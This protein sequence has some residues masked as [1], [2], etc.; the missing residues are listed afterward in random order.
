MAFKFSNFSRSVLEDGCTNVE[1]TIVIP[2]EDAALMPDLDPGDQFP[3][4]IWD[5][6][7]DPE[8]V[9]VTDNPGT[10]ILTVTRGEE[11]SNQQAWPAGSEVRLAPTAAIFD[12]AITQADQNVEIVGYCCESTATN[13][14][15][16]THHLVEQGMG[17]EDD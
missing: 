11:S 10:G 14:V 7:N 8:I 6:Q 15:S 13:R 9:Y 16:S 1:T 12:A 4:S 2:A 5:G 3:L 17:L